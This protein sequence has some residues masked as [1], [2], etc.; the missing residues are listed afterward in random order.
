MPFRIVLGNIVEM[1]VDAIVN[2]ANKSL[3]G[4]GGVDG[5]IHEAAGPGLLAECLALL[6]CET[7]EAKITK[8]YELPAKYVIHTV[9]PIY[10]DGEHGEKEKL[11]SC[12]RQSLKLAKEHAC[13]SIAFPLI[14]G[15]IYGYP[16]EEAIQ[17]AISC[18]RE[19]LIDNEMDIYL[20]IYKKR[21][22]RL[23]KSLSEGLEEGLLEA[24]RTLE[25]RHYPRRGERL[26][27]R[28]LARMAFAPEK[29][30][31]ESFSEMLL[32]KIDEKG[33]SD[34]ECY[35]KANVDRRLF[36]K[37]RSDPLYH[38]KKETVIAFAFALE[39]PLPEIEEMLRK[40]GLAFSGVFMFDR[41][42]LYF[43]EKHNYD[44][45]ELNQVLFANDQPLVP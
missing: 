43:I 11:E 5:A 19:F 12:Y 24:Q 13:E 8:G 2:A 17:V 6:G 21:D 22:F 33:L 32:R 14:S 35:K 44:I 31:D 3:L 20:V 1:K 40:A 37:I 28:N 36:S 7:G 9:G 27:R 34:A 41:I 45:Y 38:P 18:I 16:K 30:R 26:F 10:D 15:G 42:V 39:L 25:S 23:P 29:E 4:G